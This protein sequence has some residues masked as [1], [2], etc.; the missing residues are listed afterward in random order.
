MP[1]LE[2]KTE[3]TNNERA[4]VKAELS[5][6]LEQLAN[7]IAR[8]N[9]IPQIFQNNPANCL[10]AME[11][12]QR[13]GASVLAVMQSMY[14]VHGKPGWSGQFI[15]ASVN[16]TGRF[17]PLEFTFSEDRQACRARAINR[18][19]KEEVFGPPVSVAMAKAEGW[20]DRNPKWKNMTELMLSYR[21]G[22]FFGRIHTPDVLMGMREEAEVIEVETEGIVK[23]P[24]IPE[25]KLVVKQPERHPFDGPEPAPA[26]EKPKRGPGRPRL[27]PKAE[28]SPERPNQE[29]LQSKLDNSEFTRGDFM[30]VADKNQWL[31][32]GK[33]WGSMDEVPDAMF[34]VFLADDEW[35]VVL[36]EL[37]SFRQTQ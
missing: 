37:Q 33:N 28:A 15:I 5:P 23:R 32:K 25:P 9:I 7:T 34:S 35:A 36:S 21:A 30:A 2:T 19:T 13:I 22:T 31:G 26:E 4:I 16:S 27:Q 1:K 11:M 6:A 24:I 17:T 14:V 18:S 10:I 8:S 3:Q 29:A 20:W 12:A